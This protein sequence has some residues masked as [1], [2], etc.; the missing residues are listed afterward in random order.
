[1]ERITKIVFS[2][3]LVSLGL[4]VFLAAIGIATFIESIHGVQAAK[5]VIYN[6]HWF[7][8][9]LVYL[10]IAMIFNII[11]YRMWKREKIAALSFHVSFLI[12]MIGAGITRYTGY[13]GL[14]VI[15]E[16]TAVDYI[17]TA[18][19]KLLV[20]ISDPKS[21]KVLAYSAWM[22]DWGMV[23]NSFSH[24]IDHGTKTLTITYNDF[25]SN[26]IDTIAFD[27]STPGAVLDV[28]VGQMK[29]NYLATGDKLLAGSM[30]LAYGSEANEGVTFKLS[31]EKI[32]IK[33]AVDLRMLPMTMMMEARRTG[34]PIPDTAYT[35]IPKNT[36]VDANLKTLYQSGS[37]QFV[38]K[39]VYYHAYKTRLKAKMKNQGTDYL[40]VNVSSGKANKKVVLKGGHNMMPDPE[41]FE[42]NGMLVQ[43]EYGSVRRP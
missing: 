32:K 4:F 13:E 41:Y 24:D 19:P 25:I 17:Y 39:N 42:I 26:A 16:G 15:R 1:M 36:W 33:T 20:S 11:H 27:Q 6:A 30:P 40:T 34:A 12:I 5:I 29:S 37:N 22:S 28:V 3:R 14:A 21:P 8:V 43:L 35:T 18:D 7:T 38:L 9:L 2:M 10:S 23:N 31:G